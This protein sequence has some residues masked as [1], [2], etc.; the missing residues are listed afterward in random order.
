M[1][2]NGESGMNIKLSSKHKDFLEL[3]KDKEGRYVISFKYFKHL[4]QR[5]PVEVK[6][7]SPRKNIEFRK[8]YKQTYHIPS[9]DGI[10]RHRLMSKLAQLNDIAHEKGEV[11][12]LD[13][14]LTEQQIKDAHYSIIP[15]GFDI[16]HTHPIALSGSN[17]YDNLVLM[18]EDTHTCVH[19][20]T[21][22]VLAYIPYIDKAH[23]DKASKIYVRFPIFD[24]CVTNADGV[25]TQERLQSLLKE[26]EEEK[27]N[28]SQ[29]KNPRHFMR[30]RRNQRDGR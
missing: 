1:L 15:K 17:G 14:K 3:E 26:K 30:Q 10:P 8:N 28:K 25:F 18:E 16:H 29:N 13:G 11:G 5:E 6:R 20:C 23:S 7:L 2:Y 9:D 19:K 22:C 27:P 4:P 24:K 12:P 21:N